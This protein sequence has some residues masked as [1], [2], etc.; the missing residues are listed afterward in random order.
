MVS[1]GIDFSLTCPAITISKSDRISY[2]TCVFYYLTSRKKF[3][4]DGPVF[5]GETYPTYEHIIDRYEKLSNWIISKFPDKIDHIALEGYSFGSRGGRAFDIGE[6]TGLLKYFLYKLNLN[7]IIIPPTTVKKYAFGK[8]NATKIQM[9][10]AFMSETGINLYEDF[11]CPLGSSP[12]SDIIDSYY[13]CK[14]SANFSE[15]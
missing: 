1:I 4:I 14:M 11:N 2:D 7:P 3:E 13:I 8:G 10:E 6:A 12:V 5:H 15:K 9:H